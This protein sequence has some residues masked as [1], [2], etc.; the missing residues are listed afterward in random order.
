M[1]QI[2]Q[3]ICDIE[4]SINSINIPNYGAFVNLNGQ[5]V[6][7]ST[8]T[9]PP[10]NDG[11]IKIG[12]IQD[13]QFFPKEEIFFSVSAICSTSKIQITVMFIMKF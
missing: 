13:S 3:Q 12:T 4:F 2:F 9:P 11:L 1:I 6:I 5:I 8:T 10:D 7:N